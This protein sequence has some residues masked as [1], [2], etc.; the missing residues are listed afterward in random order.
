MSNLCSHHVQ[1]YILQNNFLQRIYTLLQTSGY[2]FLGPNIILSYVSMGAMSYIH[3]W[4][5][6]F[7]QWF[8]L[9]LAV[10]AVLLI[11]CAGKSTNALCDCEILSTMT[12]KLQCHCG[13]V[14]IATP[15]SVYTK[16]EQWAIIR[17]MWTESVRE[18]EI[19]FRLSEQYGNSALLQRSM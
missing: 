5:R 10:L 12:S 17:F 2:K 15:L 8:I 6:K 3:W 7:K 13:T 4:V 18:A 1:C 14:N 11:L 16:E 9:N 19:H